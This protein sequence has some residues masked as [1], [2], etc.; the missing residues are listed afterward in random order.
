MAEA[1]GF[2]LNLVRFVPYLQSNRNSICTPGY[3]LNFLVR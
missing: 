3:M 2:A 1:V